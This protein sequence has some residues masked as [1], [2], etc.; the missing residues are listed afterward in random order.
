[1]TVFISSRTSLLIAP[2]LAA[3]SLGLAIPARAAD[4]AAAAAEAEADADAGPEIVV[5]ARHRTEQAQDVPVA[6]SVIDQQSFER[7]GNFTLGQVQQQV[8][9]LQVVNTNPRNSNI[10]IRGL[11]ANSSLAV[12][13]LEYGVGFYLDGVYYGRPGQSQFDLVDLQQIEI[14]RG[15]QGT[16]FGKNTTAGA[17]NITSREPSFTT[18][19]T[20]EATLGNWN[21]HQLRL[22]GS[23]PLS[24]TL[25]VRLTLADTHRGG[26]LTNVDDQSKAA[27]CD[28]FS[29]RGQ[30]L[31]KPT[32][33]LKIRLIGD[34]SEQKQHFI[35][36]LLDGYFT[37]FAN[38]APIANNILDREARLG[39]PRISHRSCAGSAAST[40][41]TPCA[42]PASKSWT[43]TAPRGA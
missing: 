33:D 2:A 43:G 21:Y 6:I 40:R 1:M 36:N 19:V 29:L 32:P 30:L 37:T 22:S 8:P 20:G 39:Q 31:W 11:G 9:S 15:P 28:N 42:S 25:A 38:G 35:L 26:F 3:L 34:Y 14:L 10:T 16:L 7:T 41:R 27:D 4:A 23:A 24:D 18:E 5:T 17:I 13:G 12:D